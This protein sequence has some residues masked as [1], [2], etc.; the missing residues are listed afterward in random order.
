MQLQPVP[1]HQ[2]VAAAQREVEAEGVDFVQRT[3]AAAAKLGAG[4]PLAV[5]SLVLFPVSFRSSF[6][7]KGTQCGKIVMGTGKRCSFRP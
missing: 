5:V 6:F 7:Y 3:D 4:A 2:D 1:R